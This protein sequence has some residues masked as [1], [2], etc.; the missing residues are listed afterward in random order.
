MNANLA[1]SDNGFTGSSDTDRVAVFIPMYN[2]REQIGR[3]IGQFQNVDGW[4]FEPTL[5]CIDN[6][7][8]DGTLEAARKALEQCPLARKFLLLN[9]RN[10]G[11][12]G[13]HKV[14]FAFATAHEFTHLAVLHG[15]DQGSISDLLPLLRTG[16]HRCCDALLGARFMRGARLIGYSPVRIAA[17]LVF[18]RL[19]SVVSRSMIYD[20]G[21]GLNLFSRAIFESG[22]LTVLADDLTFNYYLILWLIFNEKRIEFFPI[23]WRE[24]DQRSNA[25]LFSQ[26]VR[27]IKI[28]LGF[29]SGKGAFV[30]A[31]HRK[32][33]LDRYS[34]SIVWSSRAPAV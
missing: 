29:L 31:D 5:I 23:S 3:V 30:R 24:L 11:L 16:T 4:P 18:N 33:Q 8:D 2:C 34:Y 9:D 14:A 17:N 20:L 28:L 27:M 26:G 32:V 15:D 13:S 7:S 10:Y 22:E 21:S 25:K 1:S 6:N 19:F 12:G